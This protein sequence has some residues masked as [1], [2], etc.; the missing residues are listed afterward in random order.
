LDFARYAGEESG[1]YCEALLSGDNAHAEEEFGDAF[2]TLL[3][4]LS[5]AEA[6]GRFTLLSALKRAHTKMVRR[7]AHVFSENQ[8]L[9]PEDAMASWNAIKAVEKD[10]S[11]EF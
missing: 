9:T 2:F 5:A 10:K 3:A 4:S 6:E 8:A 11:N 1:E 7:H